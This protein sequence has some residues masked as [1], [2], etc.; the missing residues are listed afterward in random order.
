MDGIPH[1]ERALPRKSG[2]RN[3]MRMKRHPNPQL[4]PLRLSLWER[5][6]LALKIGKT[7]AAVLGAVA[8]LVKVFLPLL[9]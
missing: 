9:H 5:V 8:A 4:Q 3:R 6:H 7:L 2:A 1:A